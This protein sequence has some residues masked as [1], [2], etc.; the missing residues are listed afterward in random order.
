MNQR[1]NLLK[2]ITDLPAQERQAF[3]N[4]GSTLK[5]KSSVNRVLQPTPNSCIHLT[6]A[7]QTLA[8]EPDDLQAWLNTYQEV[9]DPVK[10]RLLR[11]II[12]SGLDPF[13]EEV[14]FSQYEP[15][16]WE[17]TITIHGWSTLINRSPQFQGI[18]F[19]QS[20]ECSQGVPDWMECAI[21]RLDRVVPTIVREYFDE[22]KGESEIWKKM[23]RRMLRH[24]VF[25]QCAKLAIGLSSHWPSADQGQ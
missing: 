2:Y 15:S 16:H 9:P 20:A 22:V 10:V 14:I 24:R 7:A 21:Y 11:T 13:L 25:S 23:P 6:R 8:I 19:T 12:Y 1:T 4:K 17:T 3:L 18:T 5:T